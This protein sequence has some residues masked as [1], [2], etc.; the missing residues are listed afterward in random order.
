VRAKPLLFLAVKAEDHVY[1]ALQAALKAWCGCRH[2][3]FLQAETHK[4][5]SWAPS[6]GRKDWLVHSA[7]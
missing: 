1:Q 6:H 2:L 3:N 5:V 7:F 4:A